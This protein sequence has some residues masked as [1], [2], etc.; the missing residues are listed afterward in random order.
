V[1]T[2]EE[3]GDLAKSLVNNLAEMDLNGQMHGSTIVDIAQ[4]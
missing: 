2:F 4:R 1:K 3:A